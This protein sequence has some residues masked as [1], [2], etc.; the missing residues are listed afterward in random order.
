ME[1]IIDVLMPAVISLLGTVVTVITG[2][3]G[4]KITK[5]GNEIINNKNSQFTAEEKK[6]VINSTVEYVEQV[7]KDLH[8]EEKLEKAKD[9][10]LSILQAEGINITDEQLETLIE[11]AV[12]GM[13]AGKEEANK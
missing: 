13:N 3:L 9:R 8:G 1:Q 2:V 7:F 5:W 12:K 10:A 11:A 4:Y 6:N